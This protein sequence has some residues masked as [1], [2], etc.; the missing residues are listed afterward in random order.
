MT[1]RPTQ[2]Q[3]LE[4]RA[5][6]G[7]SRNRTN[8]QDLIERQIPVMPV[9]AADAKLLLHIGRSQQLRPD[10]AFAKAGAISLQRI[11]RRVREALPATLP[12][13]LERIGRIL[14]DGRQHMASGRR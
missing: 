12:T 3:P 10:D 13:L 6:L 7:G 2:E 8:H 11:Q 1:S 5:V 4:W 14:H 9:S